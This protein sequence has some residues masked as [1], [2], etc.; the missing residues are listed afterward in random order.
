MKQKNF[1]TVRIFGVDYQLIFTPGLGISDEE[2]T[3]GVI[4]SNT[5]RPKIVVSTAE[6]IATQQETALHEIV[7]IC[8]RASSGGRILSEKTVDRMG[9]AIYGAGRDNPG[10]FAWIFLA[11]I[12]KP[13]LR[14]IFKNL[15]ETDQ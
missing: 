1:P 9:R 12:P 14:V 8:D 10:L 6:P 5:D 7:H 2:T 11:G 4:S 3:G 15:L 13:I